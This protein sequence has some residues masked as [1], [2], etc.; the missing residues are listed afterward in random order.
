MAANEIVRLHVLSHLH[1]F[2]SKVS[3]LRFLVVFTSDGRS[4]AP[5]DFTARG[6]L[7]SRGSGLGTTFGLSQHVGGRSSVSPNVWAT[8]GCVLGFFVWDLELPRGM[9]ATTL[10][11]GKCPYGICQNREEAGK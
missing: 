8:V 9:S 5:G 11:G 10:P 3:S 1:R 2:V 6:A 4:E 7:A